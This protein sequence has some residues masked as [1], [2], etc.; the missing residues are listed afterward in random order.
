MSAW[1]DDSSEQA[2]AHESVTKKDALLS[3]EDVA[4]AG[5]YEADKKWH[6]QVGESGKPANH[7][8]AMEILK[9]FS[10]PFI[11]QESHLVPS[12]DADNAKK[13]CE[14]ILEQAVA[15]EY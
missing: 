6:E 15:Q 12:I 9:G 13:I 2:K 3:D 1:F 14:R 8:E 5:A 7:I 11:D 10:H 4:N